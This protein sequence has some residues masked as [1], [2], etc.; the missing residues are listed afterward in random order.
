MSSDS[1]ATP[2]ASG[3][4]TTPPIDVR[5][6]DMDALRH[7]NNAVYFSYFEEGRVHLFAAMGLGAA[8]GRYGV[9][10][11]ASCDF[12][13]PLLYPARVVVGMKLLRVGRTSLELDC[14]V[15]DAGDAATLYARGRNVLVCTDGATGRPVPWTDADRR[16]LDRCFAA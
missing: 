4:F 14:W 2:P 6:G 11:H 15:A 13:R 9:L 5:W 16:A 1:T 3:T 12:L 7:V 10:A 8:A